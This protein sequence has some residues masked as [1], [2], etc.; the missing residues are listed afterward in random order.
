VSLEE[1]RKSILQKA[2]DKANKILEEARLEAQ[3]LID[4]AR[5][6]YQ[7]RLEAERIKALSEL[8]EKWNREYINKVMDANMKLLQLKRELI[9]S[10]LEEA[11]RRIEEL[12]PEARE[13]SLKTLLKESI[14]QSIIKDNFVI[15][16]VSK[17]IDL[18]QKVVKDLGLKKKVVKIEEL[19]NKYLGGLILENVDGTVALDNT[20]ATR[21][22]R[23]L[24]ILYDEVNKEVMKG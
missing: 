12:S 16:V 13:L 22:E 7:K 4:E 5:Q 19:D 8:K 10:L 18:L 23:A 3:K 21:L 2:K 14:N 24:S 20:Y 9:N 15:K 17:D 1:L 11:R 6:D